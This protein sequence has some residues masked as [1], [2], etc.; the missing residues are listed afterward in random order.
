MKSHKIEQR[1]GPLKGRVSR[2]LKDLNHSYD[3]THKNV[4]DLYD[5]AIS[6]LLAQKTKLIEQ[7]NCIH[8]E[9][10]HRCQDILS[11]LASQVKRN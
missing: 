11:G 9:E 1:I 3:E 7:L 6:Q 5:S 4:E 10:S 2:Y 8:E